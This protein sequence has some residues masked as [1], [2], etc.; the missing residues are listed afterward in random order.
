MLAARLLGGHVRGRA[1]QRSHD[2]VWRQR[3]VLHVGP[4]LRGIHPGHAAAQLGQ[5]EVQD[6][7][8]PV[9][10]DHHILR[11][12]IAMHD[13]GGVRLAHAVSELRGN[14]QNL[15]H[16]QRCLLQKRAQGVPLDVL[17]HDVRRSARHGADLVDRDDVGMV[18][19]RGGPCLLPEAREALGTVGKSLR[20]ELDGDIAVQVA[21]AGAVHFAHTPDAEQLEDL[22]TG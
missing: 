8:E 5:T 11:L 21:V 13:P 19:G 22:G 4:R 16:R 10:R 6:L 1:H 14:L 7:H 12:E 2:G 9:G 18:Q 15:S 20:E 17:H 3:R